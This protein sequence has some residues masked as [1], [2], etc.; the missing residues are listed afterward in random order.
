MSAETA[1]PAVIADDRETRA[2]RLTYLAIAA[3]RWA[4]RMLPTHTGRMVFRRAGVLAFHA[5]PKV[6]AVVAANQGRVLGRPA[7]DPLVQAST[8]EAFRLYARYWFDAF[9]VIH[10]PD[11]RIHAEFRFEGLEH[12]RAALD[13][14][15]GAIAVLPHMGN[16]DTA[17]RAMAERGF[18][19]VAVA[20]RLRPERLFRLFVEQREALG[21]RVIGLS[22]E[23]K[24]GQ[25]VGAA[26]AENSVLAL[27]ADR[28]L[29]GRGVEVEMFGAPRRIPVG[30]ALLS[31][32]TGAPIVHCAIYQTPEGWLCRMSP[33]S[34]PLSGDRR[35]DV[36]AISQEIVRF[37]ERTIS[38]APADWHVFQPA[39]DDAEA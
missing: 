35:A 10:W 34:V 36:T 31:V 32:T 29:T 18:P 38:A 6:R 22:G 12:M 7:D 33:V 5:A 23:G 13:G 27:L 11:E 37:F 14:G 1:A 8:K 20:E 21:M 3:I 25:R 4:G 9:H 19:V 15:K 30:P 28:D 17:G 26:L 39:W 16:W 24:V 2:E